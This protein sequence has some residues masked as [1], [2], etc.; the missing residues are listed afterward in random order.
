M[1]QIQTTIIGSAPLLQH[2]FALD[3]LQSLREGAN[4]RTGSVD[5]HYEWLATM[6]VH[7]GTLVQPASHIEGALARAAAGFRVKGGRGRT[8]RDL[9]RA[10][11]LVSPDAIRHYWEGQP[12][13]APGP[14]LL[15]APTPALCV[16]L[17]RVLVG[18]AAVARARLQINAGW[19]LT[20]T[21][22][23][24]DDQIRPEVVHTILVEG[25]RAVGIGDYRPRYGRFEVSAFQV[26]SDGSDI[27]A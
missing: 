27:G 9:I 5:Y 14:E 2:R 1:Y 15:T 11:V 25:G 26:S 12:L 24:N 17:Q 6:Y 18:R 8:Y 16:N 21:L 10:Y 7:D 20:F 3:T 22:T 13:A 23:V 4:R 19:Q